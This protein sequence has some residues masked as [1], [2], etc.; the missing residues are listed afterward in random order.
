M[1]VSNPVSF[2]IERWDAQE[3]DEA[4]SALVDESG[5]NPAIQHE[6]LPLNHPSASDECS[7]SFANQQSPVSDEFPGSIP[8]DPPHSHLSPREAFLL[9]SYIIKL[10]PWVGS[11]SCLIVFANCPQLDVCDP[12]CQFAN[13]VPRRA[14]HNPMVMYALLTVASRHQSIMRGIDEVEASTYHGRCLEY[15]IPALSRP[16]DTYDDNLLVTVVILRLYEELDNQ[17]DKKCH[18]LGSSRLLNTVSRFSSSGGLAEAA[19]WLFLRQAIYVS[20]VQKEPWELCLENYESSLVFEC[21]NGDD[22]SYANVMIFL[23]AK[24]LRLISH[25]RETAS[26]DL[27][28]WLSLEESVER[29]N[30]ER[31]FSFTPLRY[32]DVDVEENRPFPE[33]WMVSPAAGNTHSK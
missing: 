31:P 21:P 19:S 15:L 26:T 7:P 24:I 2:V 17:R 20:L 23:V 11:V 28:D 9:R 29:W 18:L 1:R 30:D 8:R 16:E 25:S 32:R 27:Q 14:L 33:L 12:T 3:S 5:E 13:E 22:A 10:A 4:Q 6:N